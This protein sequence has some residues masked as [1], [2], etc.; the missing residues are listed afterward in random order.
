MTVTLPAAREPASVSAGLA[1][2]PQAAVGRK[3]RILLVDD[4]AMM[5]MVGRELLELMGHTVSE[6]SGGLEALR[7]LSHWEAYDA[8]LLD[9]NM[10][11]MDGVETLKRLRDLGCTLPVVI[12]S[13]YMDE[14]IEC[15]AR[16]FGGVRLLPKP[17]TV[18]ELR[19]ALG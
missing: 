17:Y 6:A 1:A 3:L 11:G 18:G 9:R 19:T 15:V 5:R 7:L 14:A 4:D 2:D 8:V 13:G 16:E 10:P 12:S